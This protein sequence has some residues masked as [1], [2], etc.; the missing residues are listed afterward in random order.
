LYGVVID[1]KTGKVDFQ[2]S[3]ELRKR[4]FD[5]RL[6]SDEMVPKHSVDE[7]IVVP[8][9]ASRKVLLSAESLYRQ[10][11]EQGLLRWRCCS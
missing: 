4:M 3:V 1:S 9:R 5:L 2:E 10:A 6:P 7:Q 8:K 11:N